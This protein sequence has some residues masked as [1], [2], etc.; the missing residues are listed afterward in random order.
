MIVSETQITISKWFPLLNDIVKGHSHLD[1]GWIFIFF[2][3]KKYSWQIPIERDFIEKIT[4]ALLQELFV[5]MP[6][7]YNGALA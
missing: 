3:L 2:R 7:G 4:S 1:R 5:E 6:F